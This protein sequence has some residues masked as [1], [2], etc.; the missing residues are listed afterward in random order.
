MEVSTSSYVTTV[1]VGVVV[2]LVV[3][4]LLRRV[5]YDF[6]A[7]VYDDLTVAASL[8]RLLVTLFHLIALGSLCLVSTVNPRGLDGIQLII[9]RTGIVLLLL[10]GVYGLTVLALTRARSRLRDDALED[11]MAARYRGARG[12]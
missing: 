1:V 7:E 8:N 4:Q 9:T 11:G 10:G 5:G 12:R 6:L 2:T 3:G